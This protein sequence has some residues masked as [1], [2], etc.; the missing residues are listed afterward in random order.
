ML[1]LYYR[2]SVGLANSWLCVDVPGSDSN[3]EVMQY[4]DNCQ[5]DY[6]C[7]KRGWL[8]ELNKD[9]LVKA[10]FAIAGSLFNW[11]CSISQ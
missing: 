2:K 11:V 5:S 6:V 9:C 7:A 4:N 8:Y 3:N 1:R 10:R